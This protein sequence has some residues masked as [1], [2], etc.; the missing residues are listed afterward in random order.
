M[1]L[2]FWHNFILSRWQPWP[3]NP[4]AYAAA[5]S[6][7]TLPHIRPQMLLHLQFMKWSLKLL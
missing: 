3:K 2:R 4:S 7:E 5:S 6:R 1:E